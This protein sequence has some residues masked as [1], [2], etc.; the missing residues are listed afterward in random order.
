MNET[1]KLGL[2]LL[3]IT[4]VCATILA[5]SN[6]ITSVKIEEANILANESARIEILSD[7]NNFKLLDEKKI[8]E[9]QN[10][11]PEIMEIYQGSNGENLVGYTIKAKVRGY[12]GEI[13]LMA[14]I[15]TEGNITG[16]KILSHGETPGLGGN[17]TKDYF[18]DSFKGK[19]VEDQ[20]VAVTD[21][22]AENEVQAL[23]SATVTTNAI[24]NGVNI[25]RQVYNLNLSN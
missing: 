4:V 20:L 7:A 3:S 9:I 6:E 16:M 24:V 22:K 17:A 19:S 21:P 18:S 12:D 10:K 2:I 1:L 13:E 8:E 14:G 15:S 25:V 5:F 11:S 23:T